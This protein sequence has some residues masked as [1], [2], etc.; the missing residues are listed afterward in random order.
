MDN[1]FLKNR[2]KVYN[3]PRYFLS[4]IHVLLRIPTLYFV[5]RTWYMVHLSWYLV[6]PLLLQQLLEA[7]FFA[8]PASRQLRD[9]L[10]LNQ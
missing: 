7:H 4:R 5:L 8:I 3:V 2:F 10:L 1:Y 6:H 9:V